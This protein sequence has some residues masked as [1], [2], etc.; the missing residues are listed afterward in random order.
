MVDAF[1]GDVAAATVAQ[2]QAG[3]ETGSL[4]SVSITQA[5]L[6]R[7]DD[8]DRAGP[9]VNSVLMTNPEAL[10]IA[11]QLDRERQEQGP[12]GPLH[13]VPILLKDTIDTGDRMVTS[14]GSLALASPAGADATV[15]AR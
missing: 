12:R 5:Y 10:D 3:M 7:I 1:D 14:A 13:G 9:S 4:T 15:A 2:L 11:A 8:V 6:D